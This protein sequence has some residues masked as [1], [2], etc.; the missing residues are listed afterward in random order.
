M[1]VE[2]SVPTNAIHMAVF[3]SRRVVELTTNGE[4][5]S[6]V[7]SRLNGTYVLEQ[8][9]FHWGASDSVG[10]E[11]SIGE[12]FHPLEVRLNYLNKLSNSSSR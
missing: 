12:K 1:T 2:S 4:T 3:C 8:L 11:H 6:L 9:H 10:S 7:N 5:I